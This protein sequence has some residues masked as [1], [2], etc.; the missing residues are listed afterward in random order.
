MR[1]CYPINHEK[2]NASLKAEHPETAPEKIEAAKEMLVVNVLSLLTC[3]SFMLK[4][5]KS[6]RLYSFLGN[7]P[8]NFSLCKNV[9]HL[10]L[11]SEPHLL[12]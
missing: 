11:G 5:S 8:L 9:H 1:I 2:T 7:A 12:F 3:S 10:G 4:T 6:R